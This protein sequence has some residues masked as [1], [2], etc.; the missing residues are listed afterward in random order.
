[1][2]KLA[3]ALHNLRVKHAT[4]HDYVSVDRQISGIIKLIR[5]PCF[6]LVQIPALPEDFS[7]L[8][9]IVMIGNFN[10]TELE[11]DFF[12]G[13]GKIGVAWTSDE[14][15]TANSYLVQ[16]SR[17]NARANCFLFVRP[18]IDTLDFLA[19]GTVRK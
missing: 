19:A 10:F 17:H 14:P 12:G 13:P 2:L 9:G 1:M 11:S 5:R 15:D 7:T 16:I 18:N 8:G 4:L 6:I 3:Y